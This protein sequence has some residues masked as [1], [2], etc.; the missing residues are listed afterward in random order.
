MLDKQCQ[1]IR[2]GQVM[3]FKAAGRPSCGGWTGATDDEDQVQ[4]PSNTASTM[5]G[6]PARSG[7]LL[8]TARAAQLQLELTEWDGPWLND[9]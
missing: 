6:L 8:I 7:A 2:V 3:A 5:P 1:A 4:C 9:M